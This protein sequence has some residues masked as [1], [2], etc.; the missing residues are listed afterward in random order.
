MATC[1]QPTTTPLFFPLLSPETPTH[2]KKACGGFASFSSL[3]LLILPQ[4]KGK[5]KCKQA[6]RREERRG[7]YG[8]SFCAEVFGPKEVEVSGVSQ[9]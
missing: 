5:I 2:N 9:P 7:I 4:P 6:N 8:F 3:L 1:N